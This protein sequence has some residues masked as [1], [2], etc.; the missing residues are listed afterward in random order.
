V[1]D[2]LC[3]PSRAT[4]LRGQYSH[5][6]N[7]LTNSAPRGGE[8]RFSELGLEDSTVATWLHSEGYHTMMFGKYLNHF[9][10]PVPPGWDLWYSRGI[11]PPGAYETDYYSYEMSTYIKNAKGPFTPTLFQREGCLRQTEV[12]TGQGTP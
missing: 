8:E 6:H 10:P 7:V 2:A 9:E 3:C 4:I 1:T 11:I 5:N 12:V